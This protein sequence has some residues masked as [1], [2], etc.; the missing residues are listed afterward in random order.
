M[1]FGSAGTAAALGGAFSLTAAAAPGVA[2]IPSE[3]PDLLRLEQEF[4]TLETA[5]YDAEEKKRAARALFETLAPQVPDDLVL[6]REE[7]QL[8][9][10]PLWLRIGEEERD[11]EGARVL[12]DGEQWA[13]R[14]IAYSGHLDEV[15][16]LH[17]PRTK[18]GRLIRR[19]LKVARVYESARD[20][21]EER[22]GFQ[23]AAI[24]RYW[25]AHNLE[26]FCL[27]QIG[28]AP[29]RTMAG[30]VIKARALIACS[31]IGQDE[32]YRASIL[33]GKDLAESVVAAANHNSE[34]AI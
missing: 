2:S 13:P 19:K 30:S 34:A 6:T 4:V 3:N 7:Q 10:E 1:A 17:S 9:R 18:I 8:S 15:A 14:I 32:H 31:K 29:A 5:F 25:A 21:A 23:P 22:S 27:R 16:L 24:A 20:A 26:N 28:K 12:H 11:I 33:L